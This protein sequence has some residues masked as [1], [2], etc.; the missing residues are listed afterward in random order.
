V[1]SPGVFTL[2]ENEIRDLKAKVRDDFLALL[3]NRW[4]GDDG[5]VRGHNTD[6]IVHDYSLIRPQSQNIFTDL[7][8][9]QKL[10][11]GAEMWEQVFSNSR[12]D[13]YYLPIEERQ[14]IE[15]QGRFFQKLGSVQTVVDLGPGGSEAVKTK[16]FPTINMLKNVKKYIAF[17]INKKFANAAAEI[18]GNKFKDERPGFSTSAVS[19]DFTQKYEFEPNTI[20]GTPLMT[21]YGSTM[22]QYPANGV[23]GSFLE[24]IMAGNGASPPFQNLLE[25]LGKMVNYNGYLAFTVDTNEHPDEILRAY[26]DETFQAFKNHLWM[27]V[28]ESIGDPDFDVTALKYTPRFDPK[29]RAVVHAYIAQRDVKVKITNDTGSVREYAISEGTEFVTGYSQK[30]TLKQIEN[31]LTKQTAWKPRKTLENRNQPSTVKMIVLQGRNTLKE[32]PHP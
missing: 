31:A 2:S 8:P 12:S 16:A 15:S 24:R 25:N 1:T 29:K 13:G 32:A 6:M 23:R 7:T 20:Q 11:T 17:D 18:V 5:V 4:P 28:K 10:K 27:T 3:L 30:P 21:M 26:H 19:A 14:L 9:G 22:T